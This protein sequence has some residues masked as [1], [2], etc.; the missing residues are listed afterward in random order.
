MFHSTPNGHEYARVMTAAD[1]GAMV[2]EERK[3]QGL[4]QMDLAD[5]AGV[6]ITF[7]SNLENG[8]TTSE[9]GKCMGVLQTLGIN[10][11]VKKRGE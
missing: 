11:F 8:K 5:F 7:I 3:K 6:G 2:R 4:T 1:L 9:L 10:L